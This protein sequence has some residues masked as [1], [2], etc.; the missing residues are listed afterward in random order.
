MMRIASALLFVC[1]VFPIA[2][3]A[4]APE[5]P[6]PAV[7][8]DP[9]DWPSWR[10]PEQ[11]GISRETGLIGEWDP[12]GENVLWKREDLGTRSTPIVMR[13][14]LYQLMRH[15]PDTN[16]EG[17]KVVCVDA[18]T[19]DTIWE[20]HFNVYLSDVPAER[21]GWSCVTG[22]PTTGNVYAQGVCGFFQ[23]LDGE[24]GETIWS[25]SMCEEYGL[26]STF[27][28]RTNTPIIFEDLVITSAVVIGWG[29]MAKPAHRFIAFDKHS[30]EV[31]WFNGTTPLPYETTYS[32]PFLAVVDGQQLMV[33]SSG[34]GLIWA[35]QP[36]TG[37]PVWHYNF[38]RWGINLSPI[39]LD[40]TAYVGHSEEN[41]DDNS[42]GAVA[43]IN[44]TRTGEIGSAGELWR[45]KEFRVGK[46]SP[47][48]VDDRLY[49]V[50]NSAG[51]FVLDPGTGEQ[52]GR[53]QKLGTTMRA[54]LT[55]GDGKIY[56]CEANG[57][58]YILEPDED[59][60]KIAHRVRVPAGDEIHGS[61]IISH[62]RV[63]I[64]TTG[65]LYCLADASATTGATPRPSLAQE[66]PL[67]EDL[68]PA[69]LQIVPVEVLMQ[70]GEQQQFRVRLFNANGQL[71]KED[72]P[73]EF[74]VDAG[75]TIDSSGLFA[76]DGAA[77]HIAVN[78]TAKTGDLTGTARIR[79]VPPLPWAFDFDDQQVPITW[80]GARYR[81][82]PRNLDGE[83]V[84]AKITT[85]PKGARSRAWMGP[86]GLG[87]YTIQADI[88]GASAEGK[89][90]DIGLI[91]QR[92]VLDLMGQSKKLQIRMWSP[93]LARLSAEVPLDWQPDT[94]Y[95]M[96]LRV[97]TEGDA[98]VIRGKI[99]PRDEPEPEA[100]T[101]EAR[102]EAPNLSGSPGLYGNAK[103]AELYYDNLTVT[104]N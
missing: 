24:T 72:V 79:I 35:F 60:V 85:I 77:K 94:W 36:R 3:L 90:P 103:D 59:G 80:V 13:G 43:A 63:Y 27:G 33:F 76:A 16:R 26:L 2:A 62:G 10:G 25:H 55:Y 93:Q 87:D 54:S 65:C 47:L 69:H 104:P 98:A 19:G 22:D 64:P 32:T 78:V 66:T 31:V 70:P 50:D 86:A 53:R 102:D 74:S 51:L 40:G 48:L 28:G 83:D 81:H 100:W 5:S 21:V 49:V 44:A 71:V 75:G 89:L 96:K 20:N 84:M 11:N 82:V 97:E 73:A 67:D 9:L 34:D 7:E 37:Q 88:R 91:G 12:K 68:Q 39:V 46:C 52:I 23:C 6:P 99:W 45:V 17:E 4:A 1:A 92:Y 41:I 42:M 58:T 8:I 14:K 30:G 95:R 38:S 57:R 56:A 29:E 15:E 18:A 61:P 101:V